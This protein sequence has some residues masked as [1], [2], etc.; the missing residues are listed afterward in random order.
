MKKLIT[1]AIVASAL[2]PFAPAFAETPLINFDADVKAEARVKIPEKMKERR[3]MAKDRM[4]DGMKNRADFRNHR[5]VMFTAHL[6]FYADRLEA[7][8][9]KIKVRADENNNASAEMHANAAID[10]IASA[11]A[12][13]AKANDAIK[14][15]YDAFNEMI[16]EGTRQGSPMQE[17]RADIKVDIKAALDSI[18]SAHVELKAA[19]EALKA[20]KDDSADKE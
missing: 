13:I 18:K 4:E 19:V 14:E 6:S 11:K 2:M 9:E 8:A 16:D 1:A 10:D 3:E 17:L 15:A 7:I 20:D 12:S 5:G